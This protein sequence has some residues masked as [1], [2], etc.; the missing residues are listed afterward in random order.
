MRSLFSAAIAAL[1]FS[2]PPRAGATETPAPTFPGKTWESID[3]KS[4]GW[5][6]E[7]LTLAN[8]FSRQ[9]GSKAVIVIE[10]GRVI[11]SWG[12]IA[13]RINVHSIRKSLISSLYGIHVAEKAIDLRATLQDLAIDDRPPRLTAGEKE[14]RVEDLLMARSGVYH[15]SAYE[16]ADEKAKRPAR[17]SHPHGTFWYY[18][19]WDFNTLGTI[20]KQQVQLDV[21]EDFE[22][23]IARPI[24]LEDYQSGDGKFV[25]DESSDHPAYIFNVTARDLARFGL[26]YLR[27]GN[28]NGVQVVPAD[29][30]AQSTRPLSDAGRARGYGYLWWTPLGTDQFYGAQVGASAFAGLGH[31]GNVLLVSPDHDLVIVHLVGARAVSYDH[32]GALAQKIIAAQPAVSRKK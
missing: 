31:G 21:F 5:S 18:N 24:G 23:R 20:L 9:I 7:K 25:R 22:A 8:E 26:L 12:D 3:P 11:A 14:A 28:W 1:L 13:E 2:C 15:V 30:I 17:G 6:Q 16:T 4:L 27:K 29:W 32:V 10:G 19:N